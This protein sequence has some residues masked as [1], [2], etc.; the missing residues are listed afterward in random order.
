MHIP[1]FMDWH[2]HRPGVSILCPTYGRAARLP[3][4]VQSYLQQRYA[5]PLELII[6]ND[7]GDQLFHLGVP[8]RDD[9]IVDL[10]NVADHYPTLGEKRNALLAMAQ[11]PY[12]MWWDDDDRYLPDHVENSVIW[13]RQG[14]RGSLQSHVWLDD[15]K[16]I[17]MSRPQS[18]FANAVIERTAITE[19]GGFPATQMHH[20][21]ALNQALVHK[22]HAF[23]TESDTGFPT[24]IYRKP[25]SSDHTH[26]GE[27]T[28][29]SPSASAAAR[30]YIQGSVDNRVDLKLEPTGAI[31]ILPAWE[32]DYS[33]L[34]T[35]AWN[36]VK[37]VST[38][39][40]A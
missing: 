37:A 38:T 1:P 2:E 27:F 29:T 13:I 21:I 5:G 28:D 17:V 24:C 6:L 7:R 40:H 25:G 11:H 26:V 33:A 4:L 22:L 30:A 34:C 10:H 23:H 8:Q 35:T 9:R 32:R 16:I 39:P 20:D 3:G 18:P 12:V 15:G 14:Y 31:P 19:A 36:A